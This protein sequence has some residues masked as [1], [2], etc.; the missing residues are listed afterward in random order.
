M[1]NIGYNTAKEGENRS[2]TTMV[3]PKVVKYNFNEKYIIAKSIGVYENQVKYWIINKG[4]VQKKMPRS[5]D[6]ISFYSELLN[7][8]IDLKLK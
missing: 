3:E 6:S 2:G 7:K 1:S 8:R 5:L 4:L